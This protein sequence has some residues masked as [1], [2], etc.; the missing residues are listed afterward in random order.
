M[1]ETVRAH[2]CFLSFSRLVGTGSDIQCLSGSWRTCC[3]DVL[4]WQWLELEPW[5]L[6]YDGGDAPLVDARSPTTLSSKNRW[7]SLA[8]MLL[9][10]GAEPRPSSLSIDCHNWLGHERSLSTLAAQNDSRLRRSRSRYARR[11]ALQAS[12]ASAAR[13]GSDFLYSRSRRVI[14][15]CKYECKHYTHRYCA[16]VILYFVATYKRPFGPLLLN[17]MNI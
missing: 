9:V 6:L 3:D 16:S 1:S 15:I 14:C 10:I 17:K 12:A 13:H 11:L 4:D 5:A 8:L 2:R 7:K